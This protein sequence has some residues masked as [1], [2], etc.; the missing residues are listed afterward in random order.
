MKNK[1]LRFRTESFLEAANNSK[2]W[3]EIGYEIGEIGRLIRHM[4]LH[5]SDLQRK[6]DRQAEA[7]R[8][9]QLKE[10]EGEK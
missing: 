4:A 8:S 6:V 2:D 7:L 9:Y 10:L 5:M 1:T 3:Y